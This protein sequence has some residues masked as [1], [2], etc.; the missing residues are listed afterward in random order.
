MRDGGWRCVVATCLL[1]PALKIY[2]MC[3]CECKRTYMFSRSMVA[4]LIRCLAI[5][6]VRELVVLLGIDHWRHAWWC[7]AL[8]CS[9]SYHTLNVLLWCQTYVHVLSVNGGCFDSMLGHAVRKRAVIGCL[10]LVIGGMHDDAWR[11]FVTNC[12]LNPALTIYL[13]C[14]CDVKPTCMFSRSMVAGLIRC[15]AL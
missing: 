6:R 13:M 4:G 11:C 10:A 7:L 5:Q 15:L 3:Y 1:N 14:Y 8:C 2:L 9:N 12:V